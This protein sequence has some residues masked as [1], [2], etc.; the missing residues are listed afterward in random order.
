M[1]S[2]RVQYHNASKFTAGFQLFPFIVLYRYGDIHWSWQI[3]L[4]I[5]EHYPTHATIRFISCPTCLHWGIWTDIRADIKEIILPCTW[6][7]NIHKEHFNW[8]GDDIYIC[9]GWQKYLTFSCDTEW[10]VLT[11]KWEL[12]ARMPCIWSH[13]LSQATRSFASLKS[14][15]T[16]EKWEKERRK[17]QRFFSKSVT[18]RKIMQKSIC[19]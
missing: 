18:F 16:R 6:C 7:D 11:E 5:I 2:Q 10:Q 8:E 4:F 17:Q 12:K 19:D 13:R 14:G 9:C 15:A 3:I 1:L